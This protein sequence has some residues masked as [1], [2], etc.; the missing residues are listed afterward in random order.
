MSIKRV[1]RLR[2]AG[3]VKRLHTLRTLNEQTLAAHSWGVAMLVMEVTEPS[4]AL[5]RAALVHDLHELATGDVPSP[6]KWENPDLE[7]T[8][9]AIEVKWDEE[10]GT[11]L[12]LSEKERTILKWCD[13]FE[14]ALHCY[15]EMRMGN[16]YAEN[17]IKSL[18]PSIRQYVNEETR[19]LFIEFMEAICE[20]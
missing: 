16:R 4:A 9:R 19:E 10:N 14:L 20:R 3:A 13:R 12:K 6:V 15:E 5:L 7:N 8:L 2:D 17:V 11:T 1:M 18:I